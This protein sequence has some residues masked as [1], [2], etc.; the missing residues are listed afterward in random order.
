MVGKQKEVAKKPANQPSIDKRINQ[1]VQ[2]TKQILHAK[3]LSV[4]ET[5]LTDFLRVFYWN[6]R[7]QRTGY[8][9][10]NTYQKPNIL[11][12]LSVGS[13]ISMVL[14]RGKKYEF[15]SRLRF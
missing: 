2:Q 8:F 13:V 10:L 11:P 5:R 12:S 6:Q 1:I 7:S 14:I 4:K 15:F 3:V 9:L